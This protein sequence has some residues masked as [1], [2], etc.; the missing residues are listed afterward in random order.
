MT[1][2]TTELPVMHTTTYRYQTD[3]E[4]RKKSIAYHVDYI[5]HKCQND[6]E[7]H[8]KRK[9]L[10]RKIMN[11]KY[12]NDPEFREKCIARSRA[13]YAKKKASAQSSA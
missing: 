10:S 13:Y 6:P 12:K 1:T 7:Y 8:E 9:A 4:Y 5:K 11:E 2:P 3:E